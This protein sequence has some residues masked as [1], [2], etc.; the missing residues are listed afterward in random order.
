MAKRNK[1]KFRV[2]QVVA[3]KY[4]K[5]YLVRITAIYSS[6]PVIRYAVSDGSDW[7][8]STLRPLTARERGAEDGKV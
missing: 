8:E 7:E 2:G 1:P 4:S 6:M 3:G 5:N